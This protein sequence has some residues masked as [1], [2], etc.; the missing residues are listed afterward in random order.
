MIKSMTGYGTATVQTESGRSYTMEVKS[1]NHRYCD[2]HAKLP[3]KLS[4]LEHELKRAVKA[5]FQRGRFDMYL[6]LDEFGKTAKQITFDK[7]LAAE[8]LEKLQ[9]L[10]DYLQL[11]NHVDLLSLTRMPEVLKVETAELDQD[12]AKQAVERALREALDQLD[13]MRGHEGEMLEKD[14]LSYLEQI[15]QTTSEIAQLAKM[16]PAAYKNALEDRIKHLTEN[17]IE[18][19][20][21]RISQEVVFFT[22]RIDISEE[23]TRLSGHIEHFTHLLEDQEGVG[24]KLDFMIQ[25]MNREINTI[26]SKSNNPE[27]SKHVVD[28]KSILEKIREQIQNVE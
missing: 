28:V 14:V 5:R 24:R 17:V 22:D 10:G 6:S 21:E 13:H 15:R 8:Y 1:V 26:G 7:E 11:E 20:P 27:I 19:D 4:F 12:E 18:I 3:G 9:Q 16:T 23:I 25:E 2:V